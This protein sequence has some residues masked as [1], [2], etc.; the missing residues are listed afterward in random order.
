MPD[1]RFAAW[2]LRVEGALE[3]SL[4][5][6]PHAPVRLQAAMRH[7][8]LGGGKRMRPLL[9]YASGSTFGAE[10][11]SLDAAAVAVELIHCYSLVHDD[12][13]AM[14]DDALRRGQPT[15][16]IA[17]DDA[18][19]ILAGDALQSLAFAVLANAPQPAER[20]VA[21]LA[22]LAGAAGVAGMCGGQALDIDATGRSR[23]ISVDDLQQL[24]ARKTGALLRAA[25]R[26]GAIA[27]GADSSSCAA[28]DHY[29]DALGLAFQIRDDLLDV[30]ANSA[31]LGKTAGKDLTQDKAT[32]PALL[33]IDGSRARL[34]DLSEVMQH[35]LSNISRG[36]HELAALGRMAVERDR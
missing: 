13:P 26:L 32:F 20:R 29:A 6:V 2:R 4:A 19:A 35:A 17:F 9:V 18:T 7:G 34:A 5:S 1:A 33:G 28:L 16:H 10:I 21:M 15:V 23:S 36:T 8:V 12:L 27:A 31:T 30:E 24:H 25:V 3:R 22:E 11:E 14:D